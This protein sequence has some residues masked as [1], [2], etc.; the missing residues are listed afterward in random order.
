MKIGIVIAIVRELKSFLESEYDV[1]VIK[2]DN[3]EVYKTLVNG[4][5]IYAIKSGFGK[6]DASNATQYL[7]TKYDVDTILNFGVTGAVKAGLKVEDLFLVDSTINYDYDV[8]GVDPVKP[9]QY[10]EFD[11]E[12]IP[13]DKDLIKLVKTIKPDL[14]EVV[15]ASGDKFIVDL[16]EKNKLGDLGCSICD[17]EIAAI[18]RTCFTNKVK[19]LS[20]KCISDT[21]EG[22]AGDF[23][24]NVT[25]AASKAFKLIQEILLRI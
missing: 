6:I 8:S 15:C 19:C 13:L 9:Y 3:R 21:L 12:H 7:I 22:G 23:E 2:A 11:D 5:E 1:E 25:N 17:M 10:E 18:A 14:N 4:N 24:E 16:N 20:I